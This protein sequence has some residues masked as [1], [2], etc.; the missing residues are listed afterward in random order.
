[1]TSPKIKEILE[2]SSVSDKAVNKQCYTLNAIQHYSDFP[3]QLT[4][5]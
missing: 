1:M 4:S 3:S 5:R 2:P